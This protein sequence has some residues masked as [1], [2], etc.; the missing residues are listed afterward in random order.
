MKIELN[1]TVRELDVLLSAIEAALLTN[2][3]GAEPCRGIDL[4][5]AARGPEP[6]GNSYDVAMLEIAYT[7]LVMRWRRPDTAPRC[8]LAPL[9]Q[10]QWARREAVKEAIECQLE[11][12]TQA[13]G[14]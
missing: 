14:V 10:I 12:A 6:H 13:E 2:H 11:A 5:T 1:L 4:L 7:E 3:A 8:G 9:Q